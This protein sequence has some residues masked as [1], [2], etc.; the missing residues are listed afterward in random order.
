VG[1]R[2][3]WTVVFTADGKTLATANGDGAIKLWNTA[4]WS[5]ARFHTELGGIGLAFSPDDKLLAA[6]TRGQGGDHPIALFDV[7]RVQLHA[8]LPSPPVEGW[9]LTFSP[10]GATLA[11]CH[12]DNTVRLWDLATASQKQAI[13][14]SS[15]PPEVAF[16]PNGRLLAIGLE[17]GEIVLRDLAANRELVRLRGHSQR[18]ADLTF[19]AGG[20]TLVSPATTGRSDSGISRRGGCLRSLVMEATDHEPMQAIGQHGKRWPRNPRPQ[21][22]PP[23]QCRCDGQREAKLRDSPWFLSD[24]DR[25]IPRPRFGNFERGRIE[26]LVRRHL[27]GGGL[28]E[29]QSA[30]VAGRH[31]DP[32]TFTRHEFAARAILDEHTDIDGTHPSR[33]GLREDGHLVKAGA[34]AQ[35][36]RSA[37]A[38][39]RA[40]RAET[41][42]NQYHDERAKYHPGAPERRP[43][44]CI[45]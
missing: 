16:S 6:S 15:L 17:N 9:R 4:D 18:V 35:L 42:Q 30:P 22:Q 11:S 20:R 7:T 24:V 21:A 37:V 43:R 29:H 31:P 23:R 8:T 5:L 2:A 19:T 34:R 33:C 32:D 38:T 25:H 26:E 45:G 39:R 13:T 10:D 3:T 1:T 36:D 40:G 14:F 28:V 44:I 12:A 27:G 41:S